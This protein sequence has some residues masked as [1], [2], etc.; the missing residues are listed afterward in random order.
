MPVFTPLQI[1]R[2]VT[3]L[4]QGR[5]APVYLF[6]GDDLEVLKHKAR[7]IYLP[8]LNEGSVLESYN[9]EEKEDLKDFLAFQG[10]QAGLFGRKKVILVY[11]AEKIPEEKG[12]QL[13][14]NLSKDS[15]VI[16]FLLARE[17]SE[18]H[19]IYSFAEEKGAVI[20]FNLKRKEDFL[21]ME[22]FKRLKEAGF[23]M[24]KKTA[25]LFLSL[26]GEDYQMFSQELEKLFLY[27][28]EEKEINYYDIYEVVIPGEEGAL[29]LLGDKIFES[30]EK[31]YQ[32]VINLL[33]RKIEPVKILGFLYKYFKRMAVFGEFLERHPELK[34]EGM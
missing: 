31:A 21:Y 7:K 8:L 25:Q 17:L 13:V 6:L 10:F 32:F 24:D 26:V 3:L 19:P 33:E 27:K 11:G 2:L 12:K 9:L 28:A 16:Y 34:E 15:K 22:L 30:R 4:K 14:Q 23:Q 29:Y 18:S 5:I 20:A 1:D